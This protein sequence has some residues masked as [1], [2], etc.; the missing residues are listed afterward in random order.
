[1]SLPFWWRDADTDS[2]YPVGCVH[3]WSVIIL[4]PIQDGQKWQTCTEFA[5]KPS[6]A[7]AYRRL[8]VVKVWC[9]SLCFRKELWPAIA[10]ENHK[11]NPRIFPRIQVREFIRRFLDVKCMM[12]LYVMMLLTYVQKHRK[13]LRANCM[14]FQRC[15]AIWV[16]RTF[17]FRFA[18][19]LH[20]YI[21]Y[22]YLNIHK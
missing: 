11:R 4:Q 5:D 21:I 16:L 10:P 13:L 20:V 15:P 22:T 19:K 8:W 7:A 14:I 9:S 1:M 17:I 3:Q 18:S 12:F 6:N 2:E